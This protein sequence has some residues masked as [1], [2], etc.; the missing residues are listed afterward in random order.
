MSGYGGILVGA[1]RLP[2][3]RVFEYVERSEALS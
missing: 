3:I 1:G 2:K